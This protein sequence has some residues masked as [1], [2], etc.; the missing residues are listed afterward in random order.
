[1]KKV[2]AIESCCG[3]SASLHEGV[4]YNVV[5][6]DAYFYYLGRGTNDFWNKERFD[7]IEERSERKSLLPNY[8]P[9]VPKPTRCVAFIQGLSTSQRVALQDIIREAEEIAE[10]AN[11]NDCGDTVLRVFKRELEK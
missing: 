8:I 2:R 7:V 5:D 4:T 1:M 11:S 10:A 3:L 6:E 9:G